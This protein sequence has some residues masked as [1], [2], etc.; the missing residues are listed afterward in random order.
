MAA[1]RMA[2]RAFSLRVRLAALAALGSVIVLGIGSLLLYQDLSHQLSIAITNELAVAVDD[3]AGGAPPVDSAL[4]T[5]QLIDLSGE[6]RAPAGE[7]PL[8]TAEELAEVSRGQIV[9]DRPVPGIGKDARLLARRLGQSGGEQVVAVGATS[10][11]SLTHARGRLVLVLALAGPVLTV[12]VAVAAWLLAG[13][14]LRPVRWMAGEAATISAAQVGRR[15]PQPPGGDEV[16]QLGRTLNDMLA[17]IERA[18]THERAFIDDAAHE[19]RTPI[20]VLRGEIELAAHEPDLPPPVAESLAS[21]LEETDRLA[22]LTENLLTLARADAGQ[23]APGDATTDLVAAARTSVRR[24]PLADG[25]SIEVRR[26]P[27]PSCQEREPVL[28]RGEQEWTG[29]IVRNLVGN[30]GRYARSR[31]LLTVTP[32]GR[33]VRLVVADDGPGFPPSVLPR[34]FDRFARADDARGQPGGAGLGLAI[35]ASLTRALGGRVTASN[36]APLGGARVEVELP[37]ASHPGLMGRDAC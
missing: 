35:V 3:L 28:V 14:A 30:A 11:A 2:P 23:L 18:I 7:P 27:G 22:R 6:V 4:V 32:E 36:G 26:Q 34:A 21:A 37:L 13:A 9:V 10:T 15:L 17:R 24:V 8:L 12:G 33:Y 16:A 19:L 20:A 29:H 25:I 5:A 1:D 31:I